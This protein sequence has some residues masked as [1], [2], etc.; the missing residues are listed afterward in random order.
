MRIG[1]VATETASTP[2]ANR[3]TTCDSPAIS[4][5]VLPLPCTIPAEIYDGLRGLLNLR[6]KAKRRG[7]SSRTA[8]VLSTVE[9]VL[10]PLAR[11]LIA[12]GVSSPEGES[13]LRA[14]CVHQAAKAE[15]GHRR[16][17]NVS[18]IA[19]VTGIDRGEVARILEGRPLG[20]A[21]ETQR[22]RAN[23]VLAG[24]HSDQDFTGRAG[25]LVLPVKHRER[26]R[27]SFWTLVHRYAPGVY[28]GLILGELIR[29]G[30]ATKLDGD[31][32]RVRMR[33]YEAKE[34]SDEYLTK[35]G[36]RVR[37]LLETVL[38]NA[39]KASWP[40]IC[41]VVET[42]NIDAR[43]LPLIR[44]MFAIQTDE[45][46]ATVHEELRSSRWKRTRTT[47]SA[48]VRIGLTIFSHEE[49]QKEDKSNEAAEREYAPQTRPSRRRRRETRKN[50]EQRD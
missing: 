9:A 25:P 1:C 37:D 21:L 22:H 38:S 48:R 6:T 2:S 31:R 50:A 49:F 18:R 13:L 7:A 15:A 26:Q 17:P 41:R 28:P 30:A 42:L 20:R 19:L 4:F 29:V 34:F 10:E 40:R 45:L 23:R 46:L 47:N 14:V 11:L 16:R 36:A 8:T 3:A 5:I 35:M 24:W 32:V 12:Y 33:Q 43:Y 39:T 27:P 44:K